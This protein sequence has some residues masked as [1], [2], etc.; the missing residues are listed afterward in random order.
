MKK[1]MNI[2]RIIAN[3]KYF[4]FEKEFSAP[5]LG[6]LGLMFIPLIAYSQTLTDYENT[7]TVSASSDQFETD[8]TNNTSTVAVIPNA[9]IVIVKEVVNDNGGSLSVADFNISTSAGAPSRYL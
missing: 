8:D 1:E 6:I 7:A 4:V 3:L 5:N 2:K 9:E